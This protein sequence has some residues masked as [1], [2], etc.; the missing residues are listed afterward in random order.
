MSHSFEFYQLNAQ[1]VYYVC[2][3]S[4]DFFDKGIK[5]E[6]ILWHQKH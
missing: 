6:K 5:F 4:S 3:L 2:E 1:V